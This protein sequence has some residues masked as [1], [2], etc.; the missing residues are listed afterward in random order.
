[1]LAANLCLNGTIP[2]GHDRLVSIGISADGQPG[3]GLGLG[4]GQLR[5]QNHILQGF[6][7][8]KC[9]TV[10]IGCVQSHAAV[11]CQA[12]LSAD[13]QMRDVLA[14]NV[15][16]SQLFCLFQP[17]LHFCFVRTEP[18]QSQIDSFPDIC[19][20]L[21]R[22]RFDRQE[23]CRN[24]RLIQ[25]LC[26]KPVPVRLN[27]AELA[28]FCA[29]GLSFGQG[30]RLYGIMR[31]VGGNSLCIHCGDAVPAQCI[32]GRCREHSHAV[33][34]CVQFCQS[35][36]RTAQLSQLTFQLCGIRR[37]GSCRLYRFAGD[38]DAVPVRIP[39]C[40]SC[41]LAGLYTDIHSQ[42]NL[43]CWLLVKLCQMWQD[44]LCL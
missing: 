3:A 21:C 14:D 35:V 33:A 1:M 8:Q 19:W 43:R 34:V 25:Q 17:A 20:N 39:E 38:G 41:R 44:F 27:D 7:L 15:G 23:Q 42:R 9:Q 10:R 13:L 37:L 22:C 40:Q 24:I 32:P 26:G 31:C 29:A 4:N 2:H 5:G 28:L 6:F 30:D 16:E 18:G 11:Q 12:Q 36:D